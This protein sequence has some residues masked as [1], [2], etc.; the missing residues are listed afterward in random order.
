MSADNDLRHQRFYISSSFIVN[1]CINWELCAPFDN[2]NK[3]LCDSKGIMKQKSQCNL[4]LTSNA[5]MIKVYIRSV[6]TSGYEEKAVWRSSFSAMRK[7]WEH[8]GRK[9]NNKFWKK[10]SYPNVYENILVWIL[11]QNCPYIYI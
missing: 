1:S 6:S 5:Q 7:I 2:I 11:N 8:I 9:Q 4:L 10:M 3:I